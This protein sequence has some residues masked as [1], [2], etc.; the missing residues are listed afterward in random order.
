VASLSPEHVR[1]IT[2]VYLSSLVPLLVVPV[3][4]RKRRF[5]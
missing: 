5:A 1:V 4:D 3:F 2:V